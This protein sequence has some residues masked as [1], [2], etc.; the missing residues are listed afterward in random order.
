MTQLAQHPAF[1]QIEDRLDIIGQK[2]RVMQIIR[3]FAMWLGCAIVASVAAAFTAHFLREGAA[4]VAVTVIWAI[5]LLGSAVQWVVRP[6]LL[7]PKLVETARMVEARIPNL[8]N[9][10]TNSVLL[11][12][13]GDLTE[14]PFLP[15][16][17]NEIAVDA[18]AKPLNNSVRLADLNKLAFR[19]ICAAVP[20][21]L[22]AA[23]FHH[24]FAHGLH[25]MLAPRQF[26]E[27]VGALE[28]LDVQPADVT[29]VA[30]EPLEITMNARRP[31]AAGANPPAA[32]LIFDGSTPGATLAAT[33]TDGVLHYSYRID[34]VDQPMKYRLEAGGSQ[35]PWYTANVVHQVKLLSLD[36]SIHPPKYTRLPDTTLTIKPEDIDKTPIVAPQGSAVDIGATMD[37]PAKSALL[38]VGDNQ[39]LEMESSQQNQR[40]HQTI[41]ALAD[42]TVM[43]E[44]ME[45]QQIL[46]KLPENG[47]VIHCTADAPPKVELTVPSHDGLTLAPTRELTV[48][49]N[50]S[51]DYGLT[52]AHLLMG[53]GEAPLTMYAEAPRELFADSPLQKHI[54]FA[55]HLSADQ[56][57]SGS[58][59]HVQVEAADNRDL[60][61]QMRAANL[62]AKDDGG[63]QIGRSASFEIKFEDPQA[64][65]HTEQDNVDKLRLRL[66]EMLKKQQELMDQ[67]TAYNAGD[68]DAMNGINAG[69]TDLRNLLNDTADKFDFDADT[70]IIKRTVQVLAV[71]PAKET[72]DL[73]AAI[74][75]EPVAKQQLV[76]R[77]DLVAKQ[78]HIISTL[79]SLLAMLQR[80]KEAT[81]QPSG[82]GNDPMPSRVDAF[83]KMDEALQQYMK[84]ER[85]ILDQTT[86][87]AKKPV[88]NY[89]DDD[90]KKLADLQMAQEKLDAF[91]KQAISDYSKNA[92]QDLSNSDLLKDLYEI[93]TEVTMAKDA[94]KQKMAEIAV[95]AEE[96][97]LELAKEQSSNIEKWLTNTPDRQQWTQED[98][99]DKKDIPMP[100]LPKELEDM[101]G[102]LQ[103]QEEDLSQEMEDQNANWHDSADKGIGWDAADGPIADM[104]A[105]GVTG[106][107]LPSNNE[108]DGR[109]GEGRSGKSQGEF[110]GEEAHG[111]GGRN[112]PTRL[113]PTPFQKGQIKDT[114]KD[115]VGGA[116]GG[117]KISGQGGA[118]LEGPV[119]PK[120]KAEMQRLAQKQAD[121]QNQAEKLNLQYK[122][123]HYDNFKLLESIAIMRRIESD[124]D[125]NRYENALMKRDLLV[126]TLET[127]KML[128]SGRIHVE[129]DTTPAS[130]GKLHSDIDNA[131]K[132]DLPAAWSDALKEYYEKLSQAQ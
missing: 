56:G 102:Q 13:A 35:T 27:Q 112:T 67:A 8:H 106:N 11:A 39:Q 36:I 90:K 65:A 15:D 29:L 96:N 110:V 43:V 52:S 41:T 38:Q 98:M 92:E 62:T 54:K 78:Q 18:S 58:S 16:I 84:Q 32:K 77:G 28:I 37:V 40:F 128:L 59:I 24:A 60:T 31:Q 129:Q 69:Q 61:A 93:Q 101:I 45:S 94:L 97:G 80:V 7:R 57:R 71:N 2:Y 100:E 53:A 126:D 51:D 47:L 50:V 66:L 124:L 95:P 79:E 125:A 42:T 20:M 26:V 14:N 1:Q 91:M 120:V 113:D 19:L 30:G 17:F 119:P 12:G 116:T 73:S 10:L 85:K 81:T 109:S 22:C 130:T 6:M 34:H 87:L 63:G 83:K 9:G 111:K 132:G 122:L 118:G 121:L 115:P 3:G 76:L 21:L 131:M 33:L 64:A 123:A 114:S 107:R 105:K 68:K 23:L 5:W 49:A 89:S 127:D 25:Q 46:A 48:E 99:L 72:I 4:T 44:P 86:S 108:M 82:K 117:G 75:S 74:L 104:S 88:D 103:E 70:A 55:L